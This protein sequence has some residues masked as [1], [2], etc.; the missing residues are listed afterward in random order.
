M[1]DNPI[2]FFVFLTSPLLYYTSERQNCAHGTE[3]VQEFLDFMEQKLINTLL[4]A[5]LINEESLSFKMVD[6]VS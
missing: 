3:H 1:L 4:N 5:L 6:G 2:S